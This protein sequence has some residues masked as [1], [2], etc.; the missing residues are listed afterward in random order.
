MGLRQALILLHAIQSYAWSQAGVFE[1]NM[2]ACRRL[3]AAARVK[4]PPF[5]EGFKLDIPL[6]AAFF[7]GTHCGEMS[8][9]QKNI[10]EKR[11]NYGN[12]CIRRQV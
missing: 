10:A 1:K 11:I 5:L 4:Y 9:R 7:S 12:G 3:A 6:F 8:R 2:P